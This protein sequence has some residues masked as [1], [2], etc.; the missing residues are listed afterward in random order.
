[1]K[2]LTSEVVFPGHPDKICDQIS[3]AILDECLR[4]DI[5]S[6]VAVEVM[7]K[8]NLIVIGGEV[9]TKA[10]INYKKVVAKVLKHIGLNEKFK[11]LVKVSKQS[12]DI[13]QGVDLPS[14]NGTD[15]G[16]GDQGIN[17][18]YAIRNI[19]NLPAPYT[20]AKDIAEVM[21]ELQRSLPD[22]FGV[23]GKCQ[24]SIEYDDNNN[25]VHINTIVVSQQTRKGIK[26]EVYYPIIKQKILDIFLSID[27]NTTILINPTGKF[28]V[29]GSYADCGVTGRKIAC[30]LYGGLGR[31]Q[32]G[33]VD[34]ETEF[35]T[36][37]GWKKID[38]FNETVDTKVGQWNN[39][40]L[41]FVKPINYVKLPKEK[42][43]RVLNDTSLDMVLS[44]NHNVLL[45][46]QDTKKLFKE[47]MSVVV[48]KHFNLSQGNRSD[49]PVFFNYDF[50]LNKGVELSDDQIKLQIAFCAD[51][52]IL[53]EKKW[54]GRVR[55]LKQ[56]KKD[57][58]EQLLKSTNTEYKVS[59]DKDY[60]IYYFNPPIKS[61]SLKQ[62]FEKC[63]LNQMKVIAKEIFM[64]DGNRKDT[65]RTTKK[66]DADFIQFL[67]SSITGK[68]VSL[69]VDNR[70]GKSK[71]NSKYVI[72]SVCY[73]ICVGKST[74]TGLRRNKD[75]NKSSLSISEY[76]DDD[77]YMY[78]INVP[79]HN[80]VL[81]RNNRIF[82]TGNCL[83]GKDLTKVDKL[84]AYFT[85]L[86]ALAFVR[87]EL[88]KE[89]EV[90]VAYAIGEARPVAVY[91]TSL[92][93][94]IYSDD[95]LTQAAREFFD[96]TPS[97]MKDTIFPG[98]T[99]K[100]RVT[101][102]D[103]NSQ[104]YFEHFAASGHTGYGTPGDA[105]INNI[106]L[107]RLIETVKTI[108]KSSIKSADLAQVESKGR[109][110]PKGSKDSKKRKSRKKTTK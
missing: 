75:I 71:A 69:V 101:L 108:A 83:N 6:R 8:D 67:L 64:W 86:V 20:Y 91:V 5:D 105:A 36:P 72:K 76:K 24:V 70:V 44:E 25:P 15:L 26:R 53:D 94:G 97:G 34:K 59:Q 47:K 21:V 68:R 42:M 88:A 43:Y 63:N 37:T 14:V 55:I 7:I 23:D 95:V 57:A 41:E 62:C 110:R 30:D 74:W 35:L 10:K 109:G 103:A 9:T 1:M 93:T 77:K 80:L 66:E 40:K 102:N 12:P 56:Y 50:S 2:I 54:Y 85:R 87:A 11:V 22:I 78:C 19:D 73:T 17:Y 27:E 61:K 49:I 16:A 33:C 106:N 58:I 48:D 29:G 46:T 84:G 107:D 81:R 79:T 99:L 65:F 51:G 52:T 100:D 90:Q 28:E 31:T 96:F 13:A 98:D 60:N 92:N 82:I 18:G 38:S 39:G 89:C 3:E 32:G 45:R 104:G 4:Q